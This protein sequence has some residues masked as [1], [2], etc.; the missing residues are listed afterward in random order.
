MFTRES[1]HSVGF[2]NGGAGFRPSTVCF[3]PLLI[4]PFENA[5]LISMRRHSPKGHA[6]LPAPSQT[7]GIFGVDHSC[8]GAECSDLALIFYKAHF[9]TCL[10]YITAHVDDV[11]LRVP[12]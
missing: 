10:V 9:Q 11:I 5:E 4:F 12:N 1:N 3:L 7:L 2:L 8:G 6:S